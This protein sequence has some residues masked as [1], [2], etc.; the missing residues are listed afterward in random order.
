MNLDLLFFFSEEKKMK[1]EKNF[2]E[3]RKRF[4]VVGIIFY[5]C[6]FV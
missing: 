1:S 5:F 6:N 3:S 2:L 4:C